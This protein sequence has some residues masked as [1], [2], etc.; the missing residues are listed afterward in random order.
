MSYDSFVGGNSVINGKLQFLKEI[1]GALTGKMSGEARN[2]RLKEKDLL[3]ITSIHNMPHAIIE[4]PFAGST[5]S[6]V[7]F[8]YLVC[9]NNV[10]GTC[11]CRRKG[12]TT[13]REQE[14]HV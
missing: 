11:Y 12:L 10:C 7:I 3:N 8:D 9:P 14:L 4:F 13:K 1:A 6:L 5:P 2:L